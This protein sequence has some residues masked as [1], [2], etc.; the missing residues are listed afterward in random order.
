VTSCCKAKD[1]IQ[2]RILLFFCQAYL[3]NIKQLITNN[4]SRTTNLQEGVI[5]YQIAW[6]NRNILTEK[7]IAELNQCRTILWQN[8]L[9]GV[10]ETGVGYGNISCR[11]DKMPSSFIISGTQ[12]GA[13]ETLTTAQY[14]LV[15]HYEIK[16]NSLF[17]IGKTKASSEALT[18]CIFYA[19]NIAN[20]IVIHIHS[21]YIWKN[22]LH[23]LPTTDTKIE[24][25]TPEMADS[26]RFLLT[27]KKANLARKVI[28]MGGHENGILVFGDSLHIATQTLLKLLSQ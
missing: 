4:K 18:H 16:N 23:K 13:H 15:T 2:V 12:T 21:A 6:D 20:K 8:G 7:D 10:D 17:C 22:N 24:Y 3:G 9:I 19:N 28:I 1:F 27:N 26:V 14:A 11:Y 5:K 25:G